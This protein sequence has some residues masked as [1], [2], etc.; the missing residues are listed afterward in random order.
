[1]IL[2]RFI[3]FYITN[4]TTLYVNKNLSALGTYS[5]T[6]YDLNLRVVSKFKSTTWESG[7]W[8][9]GIF[10]EGHWNGGIWYNGVFDATW[11]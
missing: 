8:T 10:E 7:I 4:F 3:R 11:G 9:N 5:Y 6:G 1:M 2:Q